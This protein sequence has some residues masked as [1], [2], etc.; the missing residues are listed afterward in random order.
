MKPFS[1][2]SA[3]EQLAAHLREEIRNGG[4][5][6]NMPGQA[7][8]VRDL[9][10][11]TKTVVGALD[12]LK[13]EGIVEAPGKRRRNRI[14]AADPAKKAGL[15]VRILLY[16]P[17]D[18]HNEYVVQLGYLLEKR[19]HHFSHAA[20]TLS[21]LNFD[22]ARV[23]RMVEKDDADAWVV[24]AGSRPVL[25]WFAARPV[26]AFA[27]FGRQSKLPIASLAVL[28]SPAVAEVLGK[29]V[30]FGHRRI[31]MLAR[32]E[33]RKPTPGMMERRY[34]EELERLGI[35]TGAFN[36]PDWEDNVQGLHRCLDSLFRHTPPTALLMS[37]PTLFFAVQKYLLGKG[38]DVPRDVSMVV[39][40]DHPAFD[41]FD[42]AV[43]RFR[44]DIRRAIPRVVRWVENMAN[45]RE[46]RRETLI[47]SEFVEGGTIGPAR[48]APCA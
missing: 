5:D 32:E 21:C 44:T 46:D 22:V 19:G 12:I 25:E 7:R 40:D 43:S 3:V 11:G 34:L 14:V 28:K 33:R 16:E 27:M 37:E 41:W 26:P 13:R 24:Q 8:L 36:L 47:H 31:V 18:K 48:A 6:G 29:L 20:K 39:F 1:P 35:G 30:D 2:L 4:L 38:L 42:P 17:S 9:G 23:A 15:R 45:D 10:V